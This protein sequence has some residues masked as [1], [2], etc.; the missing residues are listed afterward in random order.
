METPLFTAPP[1]IMFIGAD[2]DLADECAK[3]NPV[4]PVLRVGHAAAG[5]ERMLVTRPL[6]VVVDDSVP[7][8]EIARVVECARDIRASLVHASSAT[9][10]GLAAAVRDGIIAASRAR[11]A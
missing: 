7:P 1:A 6:V 3:A 8:D 4:V 5:V 2:A 11:G 9:S 10:E